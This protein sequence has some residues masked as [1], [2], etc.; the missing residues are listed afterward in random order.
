MHELV[1]LALTFPAA[2]LGYLAF[3]VRRD[4]HRPCIWGWQVS[5]GAGFLITCLARRRGVLLV[6]LPTGS[7]GRPRYNRSHQPPIS[8]A[9]S[10]LERP[11]SRLGARRGAL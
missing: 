8:F 3:T 10:S 1:D 9:I 2:V 6:V 4:A 5:T 7:S 11:S